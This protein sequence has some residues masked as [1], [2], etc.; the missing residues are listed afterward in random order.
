MFRKR[1]FNLKK[2]IAIA[3]CLTGFSVSNVLAQDDTTDQG[4]IINDVKWATRNLGEGGKFVEK[5]EHYGALYQWGRKADGHESRTNNSSKY[6]TNDH[7]S[8]A[9]VVSGTALDANGQ[10]RVDHPAYGRFIK[11][12]AQPFDWRSPQDDAL[13]NAGTETDPIKTA[14]D[15]CPCGWRLP[16]Q[17]ELL[18][19]TSLPVANRVWTT[20]YNGSG[21]RGYKV[22]DPVSGA[23]IFLPEAG[24]RYSSWGTIGSQGSSYLSSSPDGT[25]AY[26]LYFH[27]SFFGMGS[28]NRAEG[29][30]VRC[31]AEKSESSGIT[32]VPATPTKITGYYDILGRKLPTEPT[33]GIYIIQYDNGTAKK[34]IR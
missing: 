22:T 32:D 33:E 23:S 25:S 12:N 5:P 14:N 3:V 19:L 16:T 2:V 15:P 13:W 31:V 7:S 6:P 11:Q 21:I 34:A 24:T 30:S 18:K 1:R 29:L 10:V 17:T 8:E 28:H 4:V 27:S 26:R 9:G 20:N